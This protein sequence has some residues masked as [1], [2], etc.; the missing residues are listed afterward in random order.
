[1]TAPL[2]GIRVIELANYVAAPAVGGLL[3]DLGA[4]VIKVE[5]PGGE[6][7]RGVVP[8]GG[9]GQFPFNFLFELE[10]RG[11]RSI[12][13]DLEHPAAPGVLRR[14][15]AAADVFLTNL[16]PRRL[17][18]FQLEP[19]TLLAEH[20]RLVV[21]CI[22][23]YGLEGPDADRPG[24]DFSAFWTRS[25]IMSLI[26]H[27]GSPPVL[28]RIAQGDHTTALAG[29]AAALAALRLRDRTGRGQLIDISL[30]QTGLY[31]IATDVAKALLDRKQPRRFD[32]SAPDN[33]LFNTY[34]TR[35]G[36]WV[37]LVHMTPD[38]Y[39]PR[40]CRV[41]E[42]PEWADHPDYATMAARRQRGA[43]IA[44]VIEACFLGLD[45]PALAA[46]LDAEGLIWA[47]MVELLDVVDDPQLRGR[48]A[49]AP[50]ETPAGTFETVAAP[51]R[52]PGAD[53][54]PR[55]AASPPGADTADVLRA[56]GF[57]DDAL[58]DLAATGLFG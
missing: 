45:L 23:G 18:R 1:M 40:L 48:G 19:E 34:P 43:E 52:M 30:Q 49:F 26:G 3:A 42:R 20:P 17:K 2:E 24:F 37:M 38:P 29:L 39:W 33:P 44:A 13:L 54:R 50:L 5:P 41:I 28:S 10:N 4:E 21:L 15:L 9:E 6:V 27:P 58:A 31:T 35:D 11:K 12:T 56:A 53:I 47:P 25:G 55:G 46:R 14:L 8:S 57:T 7:M 36:R 16:L 22:T 51:F 32:R